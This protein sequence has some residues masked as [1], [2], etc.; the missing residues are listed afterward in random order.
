[1]GI[2]SIRIRILALVF[3]SL[4]PVLLLLLYKASEQ[5]KQEIN[6]IKAESLNSVKFIS[7]KIQHEIEES[8]QMLLYI[9]KFPEVRNFDSIACSNFIFNI[10]DK[11]HSSLLAAKSNGDIFCSSLPDKKSLNV[12]DTSWFQRAVK[13]QRFSVGEYQA[14]SMAPQHVIYVGLPVFDKKRQV[15]A[16]LASGI[17]LNR[18][19]DEH[20]KL[21]KPEGMSLFAIDRSG[22]VIARYPDPERWLGKNML[23]TDIIKTILNREEGTIEGRGLAGIKRI[24]SFTPVKGTDKG[25]FVCLGI[26]SDM[27][28]EK[29]NRKL[30]RDIILLSLTGFA[31]SLIAWFGSDFFI[32]HRMRGLAASTDELANGNLGVRASISSRN[33]EIDQFATSFNKMAVALERHMTEQ[34]VAE[35]KLKVSYKQLEDII[36]FL[37]DATLI[38]DKERN[39]VAWNLAIEE[40]TGIEKAAMIGK[41]YSN[42]AFAFYGEERQFLVDLVFQ[43]NDAL[44]SKYKYIEQKNN[45]F[46]AEAWAS[47]LYGGKGAYIWIVVSPLLDP[48]GAIIG[49][50]E[51]IRDITERVNSEN[52]LKK[53]S[54]QKDLI[55]R[56]SGEGILG[57]DI[58]GNHT[59]VNPSAAKML[60]YGEEELIGRNSHSI[61]HHTKTDGSRYPEEDCLIYKTFRDGKFHRS[62][63][64]VFWRKDGSSFPVSYMSSP[65]QEEGKTIGAV[66][67]FRDITERKKAE[68]AHEKLELQLRHAQ[69]MEVVGQLAGGIAHDFNNIVNAMMGFASLCQIEMKEDDPAYKYIANI[70]TLS[71]RAANLTKSLLTFCRKQAVDLRPINLQYNIKTV[72]EFIEKIIGKNIKLVTNM[73]DEELI[74][75]ADSDQLEQ[76]LMN[77]AA[78]AR[79]AMPKGG[80]ISI[81]TEAVEINRAFIDI[82]GFGKEG[83]HALIS[84]ADTGIGMDEQT[85]EKLF[86]PF[87]TTKEVGKGTGLG[88]AMVYGIIEQHNGFLNV[89]S[90]P[91]LGATFQIYLPVVEIKAEEKSNT[92]TATPA[93]GSET[94]LMAEDDEAVM[95][96]LT[97]ALKAAGY[98]VIEAVDGE[99][100][101]AKFIENKDKINLF[102]ADVVMPN[103]NGIE[104]FREISAIKPEIKAFFMSG[105]APDIIGESFP[106][107]KFKFISKP[108]ALRELLKKVRETL[109]S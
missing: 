85:R 66:V 5:R 9:S 2:R 60:G 107:T 48:K 100:A 72:L 21:Q 44:A 77:L 31:A 59:F 23:E 95:K 93:G 49:G 70:L 52:K 104:A 4:L 105:Y 84:V 80:T 36:E 14:E 55:L 90:E 45:K 17:D 20:E 19:N 62:R 34:K 106:K 18:L 83:K 39:V 35:E 64:E 86:E 47:K 103:K 40:M 71:E 13:T 16:V 96:A 102:L 82:N 51:S 53:M 87:F 10:K 79:D 54:Y 61:W 29:V 56:S 88:L 57:L 6:A 41:H 37:P 50:I 1:M 74:V 42:S 15:R 22:T 68:D 30:F 67:T 28:F 99:Q 24:F 65:I 108:V 109:D 26:S 76:V 98:S 73:A 58:N 91:G 11:L 3:I 94:L 43:K 75:V 92:E 12:A 38:I 101:V 78:N 69:K 7:L 27:A 25:I 32:M 33:D 8:R 63:H 89:Y 46:Y 81:N 97:I